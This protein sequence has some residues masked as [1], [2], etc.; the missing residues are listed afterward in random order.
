MSGCV[1]PAFQHDPTVLPPTRSRT[2]RLAC[3]PFFLWKREIHTYQYYK[4]KKSSETEKGYPN[5]IAYL[6]A[7]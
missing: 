3:K 4:G 2:Q 1:G 5:L 7:F 6:I